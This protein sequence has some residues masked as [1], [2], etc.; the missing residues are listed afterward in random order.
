MTDLGKSG[1]LVDWA[2]HLDAD[3][4]WKA[5]FYP[6]A[7]LSLTDSEG[8]IWGIPSFRDAIGIFWNKEQFAAAGLTEFPR[9][10]DDFLAACGAIKATGVTPLAMDGQWV[11]LLWWA[12]LIGTQPG[13]AE[14]LK[15]GILQGDFAVLPVVVEATERLKQLHTDGYVN[16]DAF[17]GDFFAADNQFLTEKAAMLANGPWEIPSGIKGP[18]ANPGLYDKLGYAIAPGDGVIVVAGTGSW[19]SAAKTPEKVEAALEFMKFMNSSEQQLIKYANVGGA[20]PTKLDLTDEQLEETLDP[21]YLPV[22]E[23]S[24]TV[25]HTFPYPQFLTPSAFVDEWKNNW[26][27]Y[28]QGAISTEEFLQKLAAA[29]TS[30]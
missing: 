1:R 8:H 12:N 11:T 7:F 13:G 16:A 25:P 27:G 18:N 19:A 5:S 14:F 9:T 15:G 29:A 4:A 22:F 21:L 30:V 2:P 17:S 23:A 24:T 3:P 26:P 6:D 28:V 20:W 10:W